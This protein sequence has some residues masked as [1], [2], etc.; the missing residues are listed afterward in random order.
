MENTDA[1]NTHGT[2][3]RLVVSNADAV[4]T[5]LILDEV[6]NQAPCQSSAKRTR[7]FDA[8]SAFSGADVDPAC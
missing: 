1:L 6:P 3:K 4:R 8:A 2:N 7:G 5:L